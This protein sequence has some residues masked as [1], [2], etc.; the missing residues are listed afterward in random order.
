MSLAQSDSESEWAAQFKGDFE[1]PINRKDLA[2]R[3]GVMNVWHR[4]L[5]PSTDAALI[6]KIEQWV[7]KDKLKGVKIKKVEVVLSPSRYRSFLGELE[8]LEHRHSLPQFQ[9][10]LSDESDTKQRQSVLDHLD[11]LASRVNHN[12]KLRVVRVW[13]GTTEPVLNYILEDGFAAIAKL[14]DGDS[15]CVMRS[16]DGCLVRLVRQRHVSHLACALRAPLLLDAESARAVLRPGAQPLSC[17]R[18]RRP[19]CS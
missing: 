9:P 11:S 5:T 16:A 13:H 18:G 7:D 10:K 1:C 8:K 12:R 17:R 15:V 14:D 3:P 19:S 4:V 2:L 6:N